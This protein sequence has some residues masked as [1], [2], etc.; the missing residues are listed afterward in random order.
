MTNFFNKKFKILISRRFEIFTKTSHLKL[1]GTHC[2]SK[3]C[4]YYPNMSKY[5]HIVQIRP[6][7]PY[8]PNLSILF[9]FVLLALYRFF[10]SYFSKENEDRKKNLEDI[11]EWIRT[12]NEK[13]MAEAEAL[14][15]RSVIT[16]CHFWPRF[17]FAIAV[18]GVT[19]CGEIYSSCVLGR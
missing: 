18:L 13:R 1:V 16:I 17:S 2:M 19:F 11:N 6:Y 15:A 4:P 10:Q 5:I 14:R 9:N 12:E 7:C 3:I 8:R